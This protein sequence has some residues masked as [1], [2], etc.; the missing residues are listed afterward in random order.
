MDVLYRESD[1]LYYELARNCGLSETAYWILYAIEVSG[2]S[3]T[4]RQIAS[5]FSYSKQTVNSALKT[6]EARG[7]V[8]LDYVEGSRRSKLVSLTPG[9][10]AFSDERI[11]PAIAAEDRAFTSLA[12][13]ERLELLRL[14]SAYTEAIDRELAKLREGEC[15]R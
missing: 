3:I 4:Q 6:L 14:V 10:R 8:E 12:P 11:R 5:N 15:D 7:L 9:G 13:E 1:K 2:G